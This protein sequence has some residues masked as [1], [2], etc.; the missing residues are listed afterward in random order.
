MDDDRNCRD[1]KVIKCPGPN[2][3]D[4][5]GNLF[6]HRCKFTPKIP[7]GYDVIVLQPKKRTIHLRE[8]K[9]RMNNSD[10]ESV[11]IE[12]FNEIKNWD[13]LVGAYFVDT[14][15][16]LFF[17][18]NRPR[19]ISHMAFP[20]VR[21]DLENSLIDEMIGVFNKYFSYGDFKRINFQSRL[22][23]MRDWISQRISISLPEIL[24]K[25]RA[26]ISSLVANSSTILSDFFPLIL[27]ESVEEMYLDRPGEFVYFDHSY[28]GRVKSSVFLQESEVSK[29]CTLLRSESNLHLDRRN[30]SLKTDLYIHEV[31]LRVSTSL[32]PLS[33]DGMNLEIRRARKQ[34]FSVTDLIGN[35]TL[36]VISAAL[37][38]TAINTRLNIT[39]TGE[40]G[41]GKTTLMNALDFTTPKIWRKIYIEDVLESRVIDGGHQIRYR[42]S[43]I[44][45]QGSSLDKTTEIVKS[46]HR[47]PDY[48]ILGEI[49]TADHSHALFQ[50]IAAGLH[51]IQTCHSGSPSSLITR[52]TIEHGI[53]SSSLALMDIIVSL[54]R[55]N[56]GNSKRYVD[57]IVEIYRKEDSGLIEFAGLNTLYS[58]KNPERLGKFRDTS[59]LGNSENI[60]E[61]IERLS[62]TLRILPIEEW[63]LSIPDLHLPMS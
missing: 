60:N 18:T 21:T 47:S 49:Q 29:L 19:I 33:P 51:S 48:M 2:C 23:M 50:S 57:E 5:K 43:P 53:K 40:P 14:Y 3:G 44:D 42:V 61:R 26:V 9:N 52:W 8:L 59:T 30:P 55:P 32:P 41:T 7:E 54:E 62:E 56:P 12:R 35:G 45:E 39:I 25:T 6:P 58:A 34:P 1:I 46:L 17:E 27:D 38:I 24:P 16:S 10:F 28:F 15:L 36:S 20:K 37:L 11:F 63:I 31:P 4:C 22:N 13:N